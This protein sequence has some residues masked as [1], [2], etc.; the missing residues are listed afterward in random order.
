MSS[1][2]SP[3]AAQSRAA[4]TLPKL[5]EMRARGEKIVMLTCYDATFAQVL[6]EAGVDTLLVGDSLGNVL[7]GRSST[8]AVTLADM[9]YHTECVARAQTAAW[10]VADLPFGS[11]EGGKGQ[12]LDSA[13]TLMRA[14]AR[15]VKLEGGGWTAEIVAHLVARGIPVCAH[16]GLTPQRVHALGGYRLQGKDA[17]AALLMKR[18][19]RELAEAGAAMMVLEMVPGALAAELSAENPE[20]MTIGIG[21]GAATAGQVLV[22]HDML[23]LGGG[24][25]PRF[26]RNFM[27]EGGSIASAITRY[28]AAVKDGSFPQDGVHTY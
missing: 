9:A 19:A 14:G 28:V 12:A 11:Y 21:A 23:G 18:E 3:S 16:L 8:L 6:D 13:V 10:L 25:K 17:D 7:Q 27:N 5:R 20:L 1:H 2:T 4:V 26:V 24:R 15:M 22:L